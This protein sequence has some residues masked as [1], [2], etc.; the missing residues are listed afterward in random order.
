MFE[1]KSICNNKLDDLLEN[2]LDV[3]NKINSEDTKWHK[4][5]KCAVVTCKNIVGKYE[6][7]ITFHS[8]PSDTEL[9][10]IWLEKCD[11]SPTSVDVNVLQ[12]CSSHFNS[13][14]FEED[15]GGGFRILKSN[16]V[17]SEN[18]PIIRTPPFDSVT[19]HVDAKEFLESRL[20]KLK[21]QQLQL[22]KELNVYNKNLKAKKKKYSA[23]KAK[24]ERL[25]SGSFILQKDKSLLSKVFSDAQIKILLGKD[26]VVWNNDDLAMAFSLRQMSSRECYL[27]LKRFLNYPL[28]ALSCVQRWAASK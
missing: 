7:S 4:I 23:L 16:V 18:L 27:Y 2:A 25:K 13:S 12:I 1:D 11:L 26:K 22:T 5:E 24:V 9:Q 6:H 10:N 21:Q 3:V 20:S 28:P 8:F 15:V 14:D 17:P 19:E